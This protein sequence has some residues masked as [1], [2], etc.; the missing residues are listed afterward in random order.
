MSEKATRVFHHVESD[1]TTTYSVDDGYATYPLGP[2][3]DK[4]IET[5]NKHYRGL[6]IYRSMV[7]VSRD[8][9]VEES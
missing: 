1:S 3:L 9:L 2:D 5:R 6:T 8:R 4:A 7:T